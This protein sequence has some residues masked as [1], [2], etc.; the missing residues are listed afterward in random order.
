MNP[1]RRFFEPRRQRAGSPE[2]ESAARAKRALDHLARKRE[3][4][5]LQLERQRHRQTT[6][7]S[8]LRTLTVLAPLLFVLAIALGMVV[9]Q[10]VTELLF[11][12]RAPLER[13]AVQGASA[14]SPHA[15]AAG[16]GALA[17]RSLDT[18]DPQAVSES[19]LAEPWI[20]S[21]RALRLPTGTLVVS[22]VERHAVARWH[23]D[24]TMAV[25]LV[26]DHGSRFAGAV[27]P[28]GFLPMVRGEADI[29]GAL[30]DQA[31]EILREIARYA[32]LATDPSTLTLHLPGLVAGPD[33]DLRGSNSGYVLELGSK[34][35]RALLGRRLLSQRVAR[36]AALLDDDEA[37][38]QTAQLIDLRYADRA[39][40]RTAPASG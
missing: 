10:P 4:E 29:T 3:R 19:L 26:D 35:P 11:L 37:M 33:G 39:V 28:G 16:A 1:L 6:D 20:E 8:H 18:V 32:A 7:R 30:P 14:L 24:E 22:I 25:E 36:L 38:V 15:I 12:S 40:L 31:L 21:A 23:I 17:G 2:F 13:V 27:E 34:G 5:R 9:S